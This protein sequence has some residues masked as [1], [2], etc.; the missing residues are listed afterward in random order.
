V[1]ALTSRASGFP[2]VTDEPRLCACGARIT[3][4]P[5]KPHIVHRLCPVC[6]AKERGRDRDKQK[7]K[8]K[9]KANLAATSQLVLLLL[10]VTT[11]LAGK[12]YAV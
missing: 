9:A 6:Y 4:I 1:E 2:A 7:D 10:T 12:Q 8:V 11:L 5:A 3:A